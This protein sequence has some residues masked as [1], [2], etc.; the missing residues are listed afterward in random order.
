[1]LLDFGVS[2][3]YIAIAALICGS[4][5]QRGIQDEQ[6]ASSSKLPCSLHLASVLGRVYYLTVLS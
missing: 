6:K 3:R 4:V 2:G 1:M 5:G